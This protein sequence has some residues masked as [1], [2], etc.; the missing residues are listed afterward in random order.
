MAKKLKTLN[1]WL[2]WQQKLHPANIDFKIERIKSVFNRLG[3]NRIADKI[4][5]IAGTNGK[6]STVSILESL[7]FQ[8]K[9]KVGAFTSPHIQRYNERIKINKEEV[10]DDEIIEA[11][12][13][14]DDKR[15]DISLTY[16]EFATLAA[17][18]IFNKNNVDYAVL[19]VGLGGRLDATNIIDSDISIITSIGIDH[20]EFL[21]NTID[22]IALEKAGVMRPLKFSIF[23]DDSPPSVIM[24][25]AKNNSTTLLVHQNDFESKIYNDY[26]EWSGKKFKKI[27]LP[28]LPLVG[29]F[30]YNHASAALMAL[31]ILEPGIFI[32]NDIFKDAINNIKL[33]G[34]YQIVKANPEIILDVAHNEDAANKL[35][36]NLEKYPKKKTRAVI[37][38]LKDKDVYSLVKPLI[39]SVDKWYCATIDSERGMNAKEIATRLEGSA[40][41]CDVEEFDKMSS[42]FSRVLSESSYED[43]ILIYGSFY[44]VSEFF[45]YSQSS[46]KVFNE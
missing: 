33:L 34:R 9:L 40:K 27:K 3:I 8:A 37:G 46:Q 1:D 41:N 12:K 5:I 17:F 20:T 31:E 26:W 43:R 13:F 11:F 21:G 45:E 44:T 15:G 35:K 22:S 18:Y 28:L 10:S 36:S 30:Q 39:S 24:K 38:V 23:A 25:Y 29:D 7:L 14:I 4:I 42:A 16:F 19:E 2:E 6:G 32:E